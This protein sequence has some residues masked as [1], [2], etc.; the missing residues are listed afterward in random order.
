MGNQDKNL[1]EIRDDDFQD[2]KQELRREGK[3]DNIVIKSLKIFTYPAKRLKKRYNIRYRFNP[4]HLAMDLIIVGAILFLIGLNIFYWWGGFHY[5]TNKLDVRVTLVEQQIISGGQNTFIVKYENNNNF[6][7]NLA[8]LSIKFPENFILQEVSRTDFNYQDNT[9]YLGDL[10]PGANG[11]ILFVGKII[12]AIDHEQ[13]FVANLS[14]YKTNKQ[15]ARL[16]GQFQEIERLK[17]LPNG[18]AVL[19]SRVMPDRLVGGQEFNVP[20]TLTNQTGLVID[21]LRLS[22]ISSDLSVID[23]GELYLDNN[24]H[25]YQVEAGASVSL[26][27]LL[28]VKAVKDSAELTFVVDWK[29]QDKYY[30]QIFAVERHEVFNPQFTIEQIVNQANVNPGDLIDFS[31]KLNNQGQYNIEDLHLEMNFLGDYWD[32]NSIKPSN[33]KIQENSVVFDYEVLP[34]L[35]LIMPHESKEL[36]FSVKIKNVLL[37]VVN[38]EI[39]LQTNVG[40]KVENESVFLRGTKNEWRVNS[41]LNVRAFARYYTAEGEQLGRGP[42]PPKVGETTKYWVFLQLLNDI[43]SMENVSLTAILP[44]SVNWE[45]RSSVPVGNAVNF[46]P[47]TRKITWTISKIKV[48]PRNIGVAFEVSVTPTSEQK[49]KV[50]NLLENIVVSGQDSFTGKSLTRSIAGVTTNLIFDDRGNLNRGIVE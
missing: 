9:V 7:L 19:F 48:D 31:I 11:Q 21:E 43:N 35:N 40:F 45:N 16:W 41:N 2:I 50:I 14:Y 28:K 3:K 8:S 39:V 33:G 49:G 38:P 36:D 17:Y 6:A 12:G 30:R 27:P 25:F 15:G 44:T 22:L 18:S 5:L 23:G 20:I 1:L 46:D 4:K 13:S 24:W 42:L 29:Y 47:A 26:T 10:T 32:V 37:G 34:E